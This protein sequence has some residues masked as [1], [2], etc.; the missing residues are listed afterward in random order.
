[1]VVLTETLNYGEG[2][3]RLQFNYQS[4]YV[5]QNRRNFDRSYLLISLE[6]AF[7]LLVC[8]RNVL[9]ITSLKLNLCGMAQYFGV[10]FPPNRSKMG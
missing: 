2:A 10:F 3:F 8:V 7:K 9:H 5:S 1:M 6:M 4:G